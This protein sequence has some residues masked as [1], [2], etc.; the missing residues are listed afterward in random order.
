MELFK[1]DYPPSICPEDQTRD[2]YKEDRNENDRQ[3]DGQI[4]MAWNV[5]KT[6][7]TEILLT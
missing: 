7:N 2:D 4:S 3:R 5:R 6:L 1:L